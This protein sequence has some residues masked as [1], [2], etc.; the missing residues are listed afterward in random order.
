MRKIEVLFVSGSL[1]LSGSTVWLN[2]LIGGMQA[3]GVCCAHVVVGRDKK[4]KSGAEHFF[5][6]GQAKKT[7]RFKLLRVLKLHL[8]RPVLYQKLEDD[9]YNNAVHGFLSGRLAD[10][11]LLIK[12]YSA[13]LPSFFTSG[14]FEVISVLHHQYKYYPEF[15][16]DKIIAVSKS[17]GRNS[18]EL[19]FPVEG[20]IYNPVQKKQILHLADEFIPEESDYIVFVGRLIVEKGVQE[21]LAAY[22]TL[23]ER[24]LFSHKLLFVGSGRCEKQLA[25]QARKHGLS[26]QVIFKGFQENPYPYIKNA[27]LLVLPSYSEAMGYVAVEAAVLDTSYLVSD[28]PA[29]AEFFPKENTFAMGSSGNE[30]RDNLQERLLDLIREPRTSLREGLLEQM[31][32]EYVAQQFLRLA[33]R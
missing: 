27:A 10:K 9:F 26:N 2:N 5:Y 24:G 6:T 3:Q 8:W 16:T 14:Q 22:I 28:F 4:I 1:H 12:D 19:G 31:E 13:P 32:P 29:A 11:V 23:Y 18:R 7:T 25:E 30:F 21:L 15:F 33:N 20:V 17:I